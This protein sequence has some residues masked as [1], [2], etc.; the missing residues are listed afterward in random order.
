MIQDKAT[1]LKL[2]SPDSNTFLL[3]LTQYLKIDGLEK[4][5]IGLANVFAFVISDY[6]VNNQMP[7]TN[8]SMLNI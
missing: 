7:F 3:I 6:I 5:S 2:L 8:I 4:V 1:Q